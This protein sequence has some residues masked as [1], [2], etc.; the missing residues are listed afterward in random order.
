ME[1]SLWA[2]VLYG[3]VKV[4]TLK[5]KWD[6]SDLWIWSFEPSPFESQPKRHSFDKDTLVDDLW[7]WLGMKVKSWIQMD[8]NMTRKSISAILSTN[9]PIIF[10]WRCVKKMS[11][12]TQSFSII[13]C[14]TY[15]NTF[16][17][18]RYRN[19]IDSLIDSPKILYFLNE[20]ER[21]REPLV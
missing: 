15:R 18:M 21:D 20:K 3:M 9:H 7:L 17:F 5:S 16:F 19:T 14:E 4:W 10:F 11:D 6:S 8:R 12:Q 13:K 1:Q 2:F